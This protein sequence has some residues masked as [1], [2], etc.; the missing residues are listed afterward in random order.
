MTSA[1]ETPTTP[2]KS[3]DRPGQAGA[4]LVLG[5]G[6]DPCSQPLGHRRQPGSVQVAG[7]QALLDERCAVLL[8]QLQQPRVARLGRE[9]QGQ[10]RSTPPQK[11][12][13]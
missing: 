12:E 11:A 7:A 2:K 8:H 9:H 5:R 10:S 6:V 1:V 13:S 4:S 3:A